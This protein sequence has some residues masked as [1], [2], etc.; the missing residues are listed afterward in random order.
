LIG[1]KVTKMSHNE[2]IQRKVSINTV[3]D[4]SKVQ[5]LISW[6]E[7]NECRWA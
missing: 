2:K 6:C 5:T 4:G 1:K 3:Y 7:Y